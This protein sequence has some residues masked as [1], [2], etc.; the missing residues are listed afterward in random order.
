MNIKCTF[1]NKQ[2]RFSEYLLFFYV[3]VQDY[4]K[5]LVTEDTARHSTM[6]G[7]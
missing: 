6:Y 1:R 2:K 4:E 7:K 3:L 5:L